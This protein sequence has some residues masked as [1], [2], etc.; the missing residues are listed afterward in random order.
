[1][2]K[3]L[4]QLFWSAQEA[5]QRLSLLTAKDRAYLEKA[6]RQYVG[7]T[8]LSASDLLHEAIHA[9][10]Q[11]R[12]VWRRTKCFSVSSWAFSRPIGRFFA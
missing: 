9:V 1:M 10:L 6:A 5:T 8:D 11:H 12:R 2:P 3:P 7:R 4:S